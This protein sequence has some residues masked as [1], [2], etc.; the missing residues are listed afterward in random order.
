MMALDII[1]D[2]TQSI[3]GPK[4][5]DLMMNACTNFTSSDA[6]PLQKQFETLRNISSVLKTVSNKFSQ[7][8]NRLKMVDI[9]VKMATSNVTKMQS[10][11]YISIGSM[12]RCFDQ[13]NCF[14]YRIQI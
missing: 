3:L 9:E 10:P 7:L 14:Q 8:R 2:K 6:K 5:N 4:V 12:S 1:W 13:N 11:N